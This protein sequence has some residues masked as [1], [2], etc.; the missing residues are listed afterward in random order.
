MNKVLKSI[1]IGIVIWNIYFWLISFFWFW[2]LLDFEFQK[3]QSFLASQK[4][5]IIK[6][7]V[8]F[9]WYPTFHVPFG[10]PIEVFHKVDGDRNLTII[11]IIFL[12][13]VFGVILGLFWSFF[14]KLISRLR[15]GRKNRL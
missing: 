13:F 6:R 9:A 11:Y 5:P 3:N 8:D 2:A 4:Y 15:F 14:V 7:L 10:V 1:F 12:Q